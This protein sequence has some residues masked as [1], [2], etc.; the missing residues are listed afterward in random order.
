MQAIYFIIDKNGVF[1]SPDTISTVN[2]KSMNNNANFAQITL[3]FYDGIET[4][5]EGQIVPITPVTTGMNGTITIKL[6]PT[7]NS[8]WADIQDNG[9]ILNLANG[10]NTILTA[11]IIAQIQATTAGI[12]GCNYISVQLDR[13]V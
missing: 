5:S 3:N 8:A 6:R 11:G 10:D 13:G 1:V 4:N 2:S 7:P 9:G 12:T